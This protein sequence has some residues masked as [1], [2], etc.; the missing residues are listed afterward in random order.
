VWFV[1]ALAER[2][3]EPQKEAEVPLL[4]NM[5]FAPAEDGRGFQPAQS[6]VLYYRQQDICGPHVIL[7]YLIFFL[8]GL[9]L[10]A[11]SPAAA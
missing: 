1:F 3:N 8:W 9:S 5:H 4:S 7:R 10:T 11:L 6:G 2:K